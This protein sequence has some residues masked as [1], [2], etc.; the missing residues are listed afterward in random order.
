MNGGSTGSPS[1]GVVIENVLF[2]NL[3]G[4]V[5]GKGMDYYVLCGEFFCGVLRVEGF[6]G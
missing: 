1:N 5:T 4:T 2:S 3:T 6:D